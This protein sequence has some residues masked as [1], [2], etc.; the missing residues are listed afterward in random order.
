MLFRKHPYYGASCSLLELKSRDIFLWCLESF[1][2]ENR[3]HFIVE[4]ASII[5]CS[6]VGCGVLE[7]SGDASSNPAG[8]KNPMTPN[9][10][11]ILKSQ[12]TALSL[13]LTLA[14]TASNAKN[15][16]P[17]PQ[18][19]Q[20]LIH[21]VVILWLKMPI[22]ALAAMNTLAGC[23]AWEMGRRGVRRSKGVGRNLQV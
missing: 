2:I 13:S 17:H 9:C 5:V 1:Y 7:L 6:K 15:P 8:I 23:T 3:R 22:P 20:K 14:R 19:T 4:K 11:P 16:A 21:K 10:E 18:V 12:E